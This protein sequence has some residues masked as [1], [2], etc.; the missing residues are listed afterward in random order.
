MDSSIPEERVADSCADRSKF[1]K[2]YRH[3]VSGDV[4]IQSRL[5]ALHV[6]PASLAN[7]S[8]VQLHIK[9]QRN[10]REN[11]ADGLAIFPFVVCD[12]QENINVGVFCIV[13][14]YFGS[15]QGGA[16]NFV[17]VSRANRPDELLDGLFFPGG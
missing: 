15:E 7:Y 10:V 12:D 2:P 6:L 9:F 8:D 16:L 17:A 13:S 3:G 5:D 11:D 4:L 14:S 1:S